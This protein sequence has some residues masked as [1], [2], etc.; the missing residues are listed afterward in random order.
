MTAAGVPRGGT[1]RRASTLHR[2]LLRWYRKHGRPLPW[3]IEGDPYR[4]LVSEIMLQ[5]TQVARVLPVFDAWMERFPDPAALAAASKRDVLLAWA[6]LGYNRRA[7]HLHEAARILTLE[8]A[9]RV[10]DDIEALRRLPGVGRYTAHA[11]ACFAFRKRAAVVDVNVRRIFSRLSVR[12]SDRHDL[13]QEKDSWT[14]AELWLPA[15][16]YYD[17]NQ[18][19]MDLGAM[20]C[21]A[22]SPSCGECPLRGVCPSAGRIGATPRSGRGDGTVPRRI[23]RGRVL[24]LLRSYP[25]HSAPLLEVGRSLVEDF[26]VLHIPWLMDIVATLQKDGLIEAWK[27]GVS[28]VIKAE[29]T[30][31]STRACSTIQIR[32]PE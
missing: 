6:G 24:A 32:L 30:L 15:R 2:L 10:P 12:R 4:V 29:E 5:Q 13:M 23:H 16:A 31:P 7:L 19:L 20:V 25:G 14:L 11:L 17:W 9:G 27:H 21:T 22:S 3:R 8:H 18:A 1:D 26:S 28:F